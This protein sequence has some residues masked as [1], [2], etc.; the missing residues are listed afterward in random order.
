MADTDNPAFDRSFDAVPGVAVQIS[1]LA[2]RLV[3][4]NASPYTFT[5]TCT[6]LVG[7][8][9]L[10]VI[11]PGPEDPAQ[12]EAILRAAAGH[13][14]SH[15]FV[16]H[17][18]RDHSPGARL[19]QARTGA[20][21]VGCG[22]HRASRALL[23]GEANM[24]DASS[25]YRHLP[26]RELRD[27]DLLHGE[28]WSLRAVA[29][30][31]HT[32]NHLAFALEGEHALF[33]GDHVMAWSTTIVAP[34]DGSMA[35]YMASLDVLKGRNDA[36]YWPGHGGPVREPGRFVRALIHHR[37]QREAAILRRVEL[38]PQT[39]AALVE[40]LYETVRPEL[41][42]AAALSVLAHLEDL[43]AQGLVR[44]EGQSPFEAT[45]AATGTG[46]AS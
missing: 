8:G 40:R 5:G 18:H 44:M 15:I 30:P 2:R 32:A 17:T 1:P 35:D 28:G 31:G 25:D 10:A 24:L 6:Y 11:D 14:I 34:P 38:R 41:K 13:D 45:F 46:A 27:G 33:S 7:T 3:A 23:A 42:G 12:T 21:I 4:G 26:D 20:A 9:A 29:T 16:T 22:P 37:R 19:L 39:I 43:M 36:V